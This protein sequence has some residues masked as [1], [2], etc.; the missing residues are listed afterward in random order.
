M[1]GGVGSPAQ[2]GL[3]ATVAGLNHNVLLTAVAK[4]LSGVATGIWATSTIATYLFMIEDDSNTVRS[5]LSGALEA[6]KILPSSRP[7]SHVCQHG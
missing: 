7:G 1:G 3:R 2:P 6:L 4:A 5:A